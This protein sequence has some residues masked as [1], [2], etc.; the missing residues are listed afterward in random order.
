MP[1]H[2]G[3]PPEELARYLAR[4]EPAGHTEPSWAGGAI[5]LRITSYFGDEPPL[6][7]YVS[8]GHCVVFRGETVL[9]VR[10]GASAH[11]LP[12]GRREPGETLAQTLEREL[13]EETGWTVGPARL[14]GVVHLRHLNPRPGSIPPDSPH[15]PDFLWPIYTAEALAE[16]PGTALPGYPEGIP[17]FVPLAEVDTLPLVAESRLFLARAR[18]E[19]L[20][21][22][23]SR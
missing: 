17:S 19:L 22:G 18:R 6:E 15:F 8:S 1:E 2:G 16:R 21:R 10:Q 20:E 14:I 13:L 23:D 9:V 3:H 5:R 11:V 12:G 7:A 4:L